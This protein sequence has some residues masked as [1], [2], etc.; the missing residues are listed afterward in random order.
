[1]RIKMRAPAF[2]KPPRICAVTL[3]LWFIGMAAHCAWRTHAALSGPPDP[4]LY[5]NDWSFQL[6]VF[7]FFWA[8]AWLIGLLAAL[9]VEAAVF[10][11]QPEP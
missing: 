5:A 6:V 4:D 10:Q 7:L 9:L 2:C 3:A 11:R 8:P 1:M